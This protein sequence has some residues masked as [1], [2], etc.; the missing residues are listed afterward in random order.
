MTLVKNSPWSEIEESVS[1]QDEGERER[2][3]EIYLRFSLILKPITVN[4]VND[5]F[6][7]M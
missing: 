3:R 4:D 7:G 1:M 5:A 6:P 2:E